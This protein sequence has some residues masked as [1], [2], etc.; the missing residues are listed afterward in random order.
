[1]AHPGTGRLIWLRR[2]VDEAVSLTAEK[3]NAITGL[4][5]G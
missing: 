2:P 5:L 3:I 1:M 4:Q